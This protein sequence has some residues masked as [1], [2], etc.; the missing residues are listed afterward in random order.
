MSSESSFDQ[1]VDVINSSADIPKLYA[2]EVTGALSP[3]DITLLL[4]QNDRSIAS[5][6]I[7]LG[8]AKKIQRM[9]GEMLTE[10][11]KVSETTVKSSRELSDK[12]K[13]SSE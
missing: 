5:L 1:L 9:L 2:N 4:F 12:F 8:V 7:P 3:V 11:E 6:N 13:G 10:F